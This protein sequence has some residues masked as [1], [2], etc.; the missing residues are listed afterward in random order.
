M[1]ARA[2]AGDDIKGDEPARPEQGAQRGQ[3]PGHAEMRPRR[4]RDGGRG[5]ER[6]GKQDAEQPALARPRLA[7]RAG[8]DEAVE[9]R[10]HAGAP[11]VRC[12]CP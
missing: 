8:V 9:P 4:L 12:P 6:A 1:K 7:R 11:A 10:R 3:N 5:D 2:A